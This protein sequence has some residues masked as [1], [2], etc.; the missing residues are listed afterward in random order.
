MSPIIESIHSPELRVDAKETVKRQ[1]EVLIIEM[2]L[3][4]YKHSPE[5]RVGAEASVTQ[6]VSLDIRSRHKSTNRF[7]MSIKKI[8]FAYTSAKCV[9]TSNIQ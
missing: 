4:K 3:S 5:L 9:R 7:C 1:C 6:G 8:K 2:R